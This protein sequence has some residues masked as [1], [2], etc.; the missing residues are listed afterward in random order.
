MTRPTLLALL[1]CLLGSQSAPA[2]E[3]ARKMFEVT[4]HDFGTVAR[5]AKAEFSFVFENKYEEDIHIASVRSSCG[6]TDPRL[7]KDRL[8]TF[9]KGEII[10]KYNTRTFL[11]AKSAT[12]TVVID[13]P[14]YAEVQLTVSGFIRSDVVFNPGVVDFGSV[15]Q[16]EPVT[17]QASIVYAG[18]SDWTI[19]D[20]QSAFHKHVAVKLSEPRRGSGRVEY[21]LT[22]QL[23]ENTPPGFI[24]SELNVV[25]D[26]ASLQSIPL[27][28]EGRVVSALAVTPESLYL[29][30]V[31]PGQKI[32]K[33]LAVRGKE[34]FKIVSVEC[35][36][37]CFE[38]KVSDEAKQLHF[39]PVT[40][41]AGEKP[42]QVEQTIHIKTDFGNGTTT[43]CVATAT[44]TGE[45]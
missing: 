19:V 21:D 20:I 4:S 32:T 39:V 5:G 28:M 17:K 7:T 14:F 36:D 30:K 13:E 38:F 22:I 33:Q 44:V 29:G 41:T 24:Q 1:L 9:E 6:C 40:F 11:G 25:T 27:P 26:D 45:E 31:Q 10:A 16:G 43:N 3:W 2:Q 37:N 18:R 23:K 35:A 8:K 42:G 15:T 34:P 12:I